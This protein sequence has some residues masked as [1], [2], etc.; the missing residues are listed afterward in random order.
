MTDL[1]SWTFRRTGTPRHRPKPNPYKAGHR[2]QRF[3]GPVEITRFHQKNAEERAVRAEM[4][5]AMT[6]H[7]S[8]SLSKAVDH[9][10]EQ[11]RQKTY[12]TNGPGFLISTKAT[13]Q[14][15]SLHLTDAVWDN[16]LYEQFPVHTLLHVFMDPQDMYNGMPSTIT[17]EKGYDFKVVCPDGTVVQTNERGEAFVVQPGAN[18]PRRRRDFE[19]GPNQY[20]TASDLLGE[21]IEM[22]G[23]RGVLQGDILEIPVGL[24]VHW[25]V[26]EAAKADDEPVPDDSVLAFT[27]ALSALSPPAEAPM[28]PVS[29][30]QKIATP[31]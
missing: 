26:I 2:A 31:A 22:L 5:L 6:K 3:L 30:E 7:V 10:R 24:F 27:Q 17:L 1:R 23:Q 19:G 18:P 12:G 21:F 29:T 20:L 9:L 4:R 13:T 15:H 28:D 8:D 25:L 16:F 14:P 11:L